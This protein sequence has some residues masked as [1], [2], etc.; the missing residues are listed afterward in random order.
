MEHSDHFLQV[1]VELIE[2]CSLGVGAGKARHVSHKKAGIGIALDD[3]RL[4][5]HISSGLNYD[6]LNHDTLLR[7]TLHDPRIRP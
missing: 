1:L 6:W 5:L 7:P 4:G 3:C 2:R